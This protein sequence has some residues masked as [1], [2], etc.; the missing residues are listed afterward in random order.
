MK[1][2]AYITR[3][4][5]AVA[6]IALG[7][8]ASTTMGSTAPADPTAAPTS[9]P[10]APTPPASTMPGAPTPSA[11]PPAP[12]Q[13]QAQGQ[14]A[15]DNH[16]YKTALTAWQGGLQAA[17]NQNARAAIAAFSLD[18][19]K[20]Q[21]KLRQYPQALDAL[22]AALTA[23]R[24]LNDR[25]GEAADIEWIGNV[26]Q[27]QS[28]N[29]DAMA[30]YQQALAIFKDI[31][32]SAGQADVLSAIGDLDDFIGKTDDA[33]TADKQALDLYRAANDQ[34]GQADVLRGIAIIVANS[35]HYPEA[36]PYLQQSLDISRQIGDQYAMASSLELIGTVNQTIGHD[37]IALKDYAQALPIFRALDSGSQE[38]HVLN[39]MAFSYRNLGRS[40]DEEHAAEQALQV[41]RSV[42]DR[43]NQ[44]VALGN[45]GDLAEK[46]THYDTALDDFKQQAALDHA[47]GWRIG[48]GGALY[49]L[50][51]VQRQLREYDASMDN[52]QQALALYRAVHYRHGEAGALV[53]LASLLSSLGRDEEAVQDSS[54][55]AGIDEAIGAKRGEVDALLTG[56]IAEVNLRRTSD[57]IRDLNASLQIAKAIGDDDQVATTYY[58]LGALY[59]RTG[60][61]KQEYDDDHQ[62]LVM[63]LAEQNVL[64]E[65]ITLIDI[66]SADVSLGK[67]QAGLQAARQAVVL[68]RRQ[69]QSER[70]WGGLRALANAESALDMRAAAIADYTGALDQIES[71]RAGLG[72]TSA[73]T[74]YFSTKLSLYDDFIQYL[75]QLNARFPGKGY[76]RQALQILERKQAREAL[77]QIGRSAARQF[78]GVPESV[79]SSDTEA[80]LAVD[81]A[82]TMLTYTE[83]VPKPDPAAVASATQQ[84]HDVTAKRNG[85]EAQI[86]TRYPAYYALQ[87]PSPIDS[88]TLQKKVIN[89]GEVL[90]IYDVGD[91]RTLLWVISRDH[92][93]LVTESGT[94]QIQRRVAALR[95]HT[96]RIQADVDKQMLP[97][98]ISDD[99]AQDLP[100]FAADSF[101]LY[102]VLVPKSIAPTVGR[103]RALVIVP[104]GSLYDLP[105]EMLVT[106]DPAHGAG[107]PHYLVQQH[108]IS[109]I[110]SASLLG[111]V[112]A[113]MQARREA[114]DPLLALARP[115]IGNAVVAVASA[116]TDTY[117]T[118]QTRAMRAVVG[119]SSQD[120]AAAF[121]DLP[122]SQVEADDVRQVLNAPAGSILTGEDASRAKVLAL[123]GTG[124]LKDYR[125]LLF[126]THAV[127]P[128]Q[129]QG[130]TQPALVLAHP[131]N[132]DG[133]LTMADIFGLTLDADF[134]TLSACNTGAG[135]H[136]AGE[137]ISGLTRA[138]LFAGTP[139]M[140]VTLW[141]V[142]DQVAPKLTPA[143]FSSLN[144]GK[145]PAES[146]RQ[147]KLT[148]INDSDPRFAHPFSWAPTV[149]FGDG[150][151][152]VLPR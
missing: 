24:A 89:P 141:E 137:G 133:F 46:Q 62:A 5:L 113:S 29:D 27:A 83:A 34:R 26:Q 96:A 81:D 131:E 69:G 59:G 54:A 70:L 4:A 1:S 130:L 90:L 124:Q 118:E 3:L 51:D 60:H 151:T 18:V 2:G 121:P 102:N 125:Y 74:T 57:A 143:F 49:Q 134:V 21:E 120:L 86:K 48:E 25:A 72:A 9:S 136:A 20:A 128:D 94:A 140:S 65:G 32:D 123:N 139:A 142:D 38:A 33:M 13:I 97:S 146:L 45:L 39:D 148:L 95:A 42:D 112:R 75:W 144:A 55:A 15:F 92:F 101:A 126:A 110:P 147:A 61:P 41:A 16:D 135:P 66:A 99:A 53:A 98:Q 37:D 87:H 56:A 36:L 30:S 108:A 31:N 79:V 78:A 127:L 115:A 100:G 116:D 73:R 40:G 80:E 109:Y 119:D 117:A 35:G 14:T 105:F 47:I 122:G 28:K 106:Q 23:H 85:L 82:R 91:A 17:Q 114:A 71:T 103:A 7:V 104:T 10:V 44:A 93:Q 145:S 22:N 150:D 76:D 88:T 50:A 149:V 132:G 8:T 67:N 68:A 12:Q 52:V 152:A 63:F 129:I 43:R 58:A 107:R 111:A 11:L 64:G 77:E 19:G 138:F 84:L 6:F